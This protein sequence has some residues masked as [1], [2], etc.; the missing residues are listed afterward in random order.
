[1]RGVE[2]V[3]VSMEK[4]RKRGKVIGMVCMY[5]ISWIGSVRT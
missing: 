5:E 2:K 4:K 3:V 1:M